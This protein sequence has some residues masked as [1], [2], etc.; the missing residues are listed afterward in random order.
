MIFMWNHV[1]S[2]M[3]KNRHIFEKMPNADLNEIQGRPPQ[4]N[5]VKFGVRH[6]KNSRRTKISP[7][8]LKFEICCGYTTKFGHSK[9][10]HPAQISPW[11]VGLA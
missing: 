7:K 3:I 1:G 2:T 9:A 10:L 5:F 11:P 4:Q 8:I 6:I